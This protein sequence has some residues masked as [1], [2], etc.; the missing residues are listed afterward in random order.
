MRHPS[1]R[2]IAAR[3]LQASLSKLIKY[4]NQEEWEKVREAV[5]DWERHGDM[6]PFS[7]WIQ[8]FYGRE[9]H[10][11]K[12]PLV[13]KVLADPDSIYEVGTE[14]FQRQTF[15]DLDR[16]GED[17]P[18]QFDEGE[19]PSWNVLSSPKAVK[20]QWLI[21]FTNDAEAIACDG[22]EY[23]Q[24]D[25]RRLGNQ[26]TMSTD[27]Y[28]TRGDYNFAYLLSDKD[29][30]KGFR[31]AHEAVVFRAD[32][33]RA[34]H[35]GDYEHQVIFMGYAAEDI[36]P[37]V[38]RYDEWFANGYGRNG[39]YDEDGFKTITEAAEWVAR[40]FQKYQDKLTC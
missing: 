10:P 28:R 11:T 26:P 29:H 32:G 15:E 7:E 18:W 35:E 9:G 19:D 24:P 38:N 2:R 27:A 33:V 37:L 3:F 6:D 34:F 22:F 8:R 17:W 21:H 12:D 20:N 1:P 13:H 36:V 40:N 16:S 39:V 4:L 31:Y 14:D 5:Q 25:Y 30:K 23:G